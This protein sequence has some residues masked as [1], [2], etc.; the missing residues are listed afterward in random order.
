AA[1]PANAPA[2]KQSSENQSSPN[3]SSSARQ[4]V[5]TIRSGGMWL[6]RTTPTGGSSG[7]GVPIAPAKGGNYTTP[8]R[9]EFA[10]ESAVRRVH[11]RDP[12]GQ[13]RRHGRRDGCGPRA[14]EH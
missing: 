13:A 3:P 14:D 5:R 12:Q 7:I 6:P 8:A 10:R 9:V 1:M 4:A 11:G 2:K